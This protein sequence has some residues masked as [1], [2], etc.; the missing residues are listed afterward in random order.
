MAYQ[1]TVTRKMLFGGTVTKT[2]KITPTGKTVTKV[3]KKIVKSKATPSYPRT[4][5]GMAKKRVKTTTIIR[6]KKIRPKVKVVTSRPATG[7]KR[8]EAGLLRYK[9]E[10]VTPR[11]VTRKRTRVSY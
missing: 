9:P 1:K 4:P 11:K 10:K 2:K 5:V 8:R 3:R 6:T 7:K